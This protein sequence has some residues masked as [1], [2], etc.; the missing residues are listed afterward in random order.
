MF[1]SKLTE[2][3]LQTSQLKKLRKQFLGLPNM[4]EFGWAVKKIYMKEKC[5]EFVHENSL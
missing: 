1:N 5:V 4:L 3:A 2:F